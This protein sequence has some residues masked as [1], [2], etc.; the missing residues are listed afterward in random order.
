MPPDTDEIRYRIFR[1]IEAN[2]NISQRQLA[3]EM[4]VSLGKANYLLNA[5]I[6]KGLVKAGNFKRN[7]GKLSKVAYLLTPVGIS[8]R[9]QLTRRYLIRKEKEYEALRTEINALKKEVTSNDYR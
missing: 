7:K 6:E 8:E 1:L 2:P 5:L 4:G 9:I 3:H